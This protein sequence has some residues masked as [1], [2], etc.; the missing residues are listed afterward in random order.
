MVNNTLIGF[1]SNILVIL[2]TL[3]FMFA[4]NW[5]LTALAL[6][7]VPGFVL[8]TQRVGKARQ[9]LQGRIQ[10]CLSALTVQLTEQ[11]GVSGALLTRIFHREQ[12]E[13]ERFAAANRDL[14]RLY[15]RQSVVGRWLF[16]WIGM[17]S[18]IGPALLWGY[19]GW[20]VIHR[21]LG[22]GTIVAFTALL[23]RLYLPFSQLAQVQ[24]NLLS[25]IALFRRIFAILDIA[26][27]V[28]DGPVALPSDGVRG[29]IRLEGVSFAYRS[30][31]ANAPCVLRR[32][33][34]TVE[35]G[36]VVALVGPSGAGK[37]TLLHLLPRFSDPTE[38][39]IRLDGV[40]VRR[41]TLASLRA[42]MGLVPQD[43]Y[44]VHDTI[45]QNLRIARESATEE[46][47]VQACRAAHIHDMIAHLPQGYDT[48]VGERGYRLS[49]GERQRL[50]IA[51]VLLRAPRIVLL[52]EA[53]SSL[54]T[55][56]ERRIQAALATLMHGRTAVV[57]A[58]RLSTVLAA[59]RI[60]VLDRGEIAAT[61]RHA[62]L[63]AGCDLYRR[64][65][66]AQFARE[67]RPDA[68][69]GD[70]DADVPMETD[71]THIVD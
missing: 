27:E 13:T 37:T 60:V 31:A 23:N 7:V 12:R 33:A 58:H 57:I 59:D 42:Q 19:G 15:V 62:D 54:D 45:R 65:Y 48:V 29:Q 26:P 17:F 41:F 28:E 39:C 9:K 50:A 4:M 24:V 25:S 44:F 36:Q 8:P 32:I 71:V 55:L 3:A 61:G 11:F 22:L 1:A 46:E 64:L 35:P 16:M 38:G 69:A 52:D 70:P 51:R 6:I 20:L 10:E 21:A 30:G 63:L 49:G 68:R 53:T 2:F 47:M 14:R 56:V 67:G 40:D 18:S 66:E 5:K 43:P 34:L